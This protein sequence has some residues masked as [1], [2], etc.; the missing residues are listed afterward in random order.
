MSAATKVLLYSSGMDSWCARHLWR[1]DVCLY[2]DTGGRYADA[3]LERLD[4]G[5]DVVGLPMRQWEREDAIVPLRNLLFACLAAQYGGNDGATQVALAAT[6]GDRTRDKSDEF[7]GRSSDLLSWLWGPQW[8]TPGKRVDVVLPWKQLTKAGLVGAYLAAGGDADALRDR[9]LSC[10]HPTPAG[11]HCGACKA[12]ARRWVAFAAN[13]L[14]GHPDCRDYVTRHIVP[15][16]GNGRGE[17]DRD[18]L[19]A[20]EV[21]Q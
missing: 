9:T 1:P 19:R 6:A 8:W 15:T 18:V 7:A 10:Y 13:G 12:C 5:V 2:V 20:L 11:E 16:L 21:A 3:E 4:D 14:P 17:E